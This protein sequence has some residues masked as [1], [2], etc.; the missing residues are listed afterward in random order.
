[1]FVLETRSLYVLLQEDNVLNQELV[2]GVADIVHLYV[3]AV[4]AALVLG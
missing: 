3:T 2:T 4:A 1:M